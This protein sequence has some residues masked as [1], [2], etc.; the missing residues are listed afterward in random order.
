MKAY[1][2]VAAT[3]FSLL[4][5]MVAYSQQHQRQIT[6]DE[7]I[8]ILSL[9]ST[10]AKV[11]RLNFQNTQLSFENYKKGLLPSFAFN[12]SPIN[13]NRSLRMLQQPTDGSYSYV[14]D[15]SN[16]SNWGVTM[17][18][19]VGFSGGELNVGTRLNYLNEFSQKRS[20]FSTTPFTIGYS[21]QLWGGDKSHRWEKSIKCAKNE[22]S[23]KNHCSRLS[24]IHKEALGLNC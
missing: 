11:E 10:P 22:V 12:M 5:S 13:F 23:I 21:Q 15:Y 20:S 3:V 4:V 8:N 14:E 6:L 17:R 1:K 2:S 9:E 16:N 18:Q 19:K 7:V 24:E